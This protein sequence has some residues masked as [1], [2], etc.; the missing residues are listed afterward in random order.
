VTP[1]GY[2]FTGAPIHFD[3]DGVWPMA[4]NPSIA[5]LPEGS[6]VYNLAQRFNVMYWELLASL[7]DAF[8]T[9]P[10][11]K[12]TAAIEMRF[13]LEVAAKGL[14]QTPIGPG[15]HET[16]GP[17]FEPP[18]AVAGAP[19]PAASAAVRRKPIDHKGMPASPL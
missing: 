13:S 15:S 8:N 17:S 14:M 19:P 4:D 11:A 10:D 6:Y 3:P 5:K 12:I 9:D 7:H 18:P 1:D 16:A 2:G